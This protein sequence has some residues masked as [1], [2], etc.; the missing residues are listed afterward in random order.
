MCEVHYSTVY[1]VFRKWSGH[2]VFKITH[3]KIINT[4]YDN[5]NNELIRDMYLD[6]ADILNK[7]AYE[8]V[9]YTYKYK[10]KKATRV[11][12]ISDDIY[13]IPLTVHIAAPFMHDSELTEEVIKCLPFKLKNLKRKPKN[14][15]ADGGY[16]NAF[17][18]H[19]LR[20]KVNLIYPYR[21]NQKAKNSESEK[22]LLKKRYKIENVNSWMK[23]NKRLTM[24]VDRINET[25]MSTLYLRALHITGLKIVKHNIII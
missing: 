11:S 18:K 7:L 21:K 24:R 15:I 16:I 1:K 23:N 4:I 5:G 19:K 9:D 10:N 25:F 22:I 13:D 3:E 2:N 8:S 17:V 14:L 20:T 12:I 6:S